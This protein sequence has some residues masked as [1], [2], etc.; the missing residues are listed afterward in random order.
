MRWFTNSELSTWRECRRKWYLTYFRKLAPKVKHVGGSRDTG[1]VVHAVLAHGY[2]HNWEIDIPAAVAYSVYALQENEVH[3]PECATCIKEISKI[4]ELATLMVQGYVEWLA[5]TGADSDYEI[6]SAETPVSYELPDWP[7]VGLLGKLD[8]KVKRIS[9][10][11]SAFM[12]HKTVQNLG[13]LPKTAHIDTQFKFYHL[14]E[15]ATSTGVTDGVILNMMRRVKRTGRANPP[16]Y[17]RHEV[18]HNDEELR[19]FWYQVMAEIGG[20]LE[21]E[22]FLTEKVPRIGHGEIYPSPSKDCSWKCDFF[23]VCPMIDRDEDPE[24]FLDKAYI[25]IDPL[26]YYE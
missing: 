15:R 22:Q 24:G 21:F 20:I 13:D 19:R 3:D 11:F 25:Q 14:L 5:E 2:E 12:D 17:G 10:G 16:F 8:L 1:N 4:S 26:R 7:G 6:L 23:S 18:R 9:D